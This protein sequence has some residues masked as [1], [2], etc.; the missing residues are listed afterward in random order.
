MGCVTGYA[1]ADVPLKYVD[2][3][4]DRRGRLK[5]YYFRRGGVRHRLPDEPGTVEF[6]ETYQALLGELS[7]NCA[8][9]ATDRRDYPRGSFGALALAYLASATFKEK[10]ASTQ[11]LYRRVLDNLSAENGSKPVR[12]LRRR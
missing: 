9:P 1:M 10:A 8:D 5:Y 7:K 6:A 3:Q 2:A 11:T 12:L 4:R